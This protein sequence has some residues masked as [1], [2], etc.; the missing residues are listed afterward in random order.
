MGSRPLEL[1]VISAKGLKDIGKLSK[2]DVYVAV[3]INGDSRTEQRTPVDQDGGSSPKWSHPMK[4]TINESNQMKLDFRLRHERVLLGDKDVGEVHLPIKELLDKASSGDNSNSVLAEFP[5]RTSSGKERGKLKISYK[6]GAPTQAT[7]YYP[8]PGAAAMPPPGMNYPPPG[9]AA[10][11]PPGM[12]YPPPGPGMPPPGMNYPPPAGYPAQPGYPGPSAYGGG[13]GYPAAPPPQYGA[14]P[15][16]G[17][18][19][20][21]PGGYQYYQQQPPRKSGGGMGMGAAVGA[22]VV[23]GVIGGLVLGEVVSD[24]VDFDDGGFDCDF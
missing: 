16:Y 1:T 10:M 24:V 21:A 14:P 22:G 20:G 9:A 23:G 17:Y 4:F 5:V 19:G 15:Q 12:N 18:Q 8:P 7:P 13:Y 3:T 2:M 6:L 11:P